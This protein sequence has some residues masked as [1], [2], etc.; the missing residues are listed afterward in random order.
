MT[1]ATLQVNATLAQIMPSLPA[2][3]TAT[4]RRMEPTVFPIIAY[5]LTSDRLSIPELRDL[6]KFQVVPWLTT[7]PGLAKV[8]MVGGS[9]AEVQVVVD[10]RRL[11]QYGLS[12]SDLVSALS[13]ANVLQ[14]IGRVEDHNKL[15]LVVSN[16]NLV[17]TEQVKDVVVRSDARSV[18]RVRDVAGVNDGV[19]PQWVRVVEDG[20]NAVLFQVYEQPD[21]NAVQIAAAVRD[22]LAS[23]KWPD[24][25]NVANWYDQSTFGGNDHCGG[26]RS[27]E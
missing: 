21:G 12:L 3:T 19:V 11:D 22:R 17:K 18:V 13:A 2:G 8:D 5:G 10:P 16:A 27:G 20:K 24:G 25:V 26:F 23:F 1:A 4:T 9:D 7:I 6:V 14:A 15:Y